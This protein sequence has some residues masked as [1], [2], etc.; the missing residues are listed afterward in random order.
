VYSTFYR[1]YDPAT[2]RFTGVDPLADTTP[3]W[4]PYQF[5][6]GNPIAVNDP[7]GALSFYD[8]SDLLQAI[9]QGK[10]PEGI[11]TNSS[12][13]GGGAANFDLAADIS[14][15]NGRV[16]YYSLSNVGISQPFPNSKGMNIGDVGINAIF[17]PI[18]GIANEKIQ[19][20]EFERENIAQVGEWADHVETGIDMI[21]Y[22]VVR[23]HQEGRFAEGLEFAEIIGKNSGRLAIGVQVGLIG[24]DAVQ[25]KN[26]KIGA[27]TFVFNTTQA[28]A[29]TGSSVVVASAMG[30]AIGGVVGA[31]VGLTVA[32][33]FE[34]VNQLYEYTQAGI[35]S[36][37]YETSRMNWAAY[38]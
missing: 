19:S 31:A 14:T 25:L 16:G 3:D 24:Y 21:N 34:T 30:G 28:V 17:H 1:T 35:D 29:S 9:A 18:K 12:G 13:G 4:N 27:G 8:W 38:H 37:A 33:V 7:T 36:I 22:G 23:M 11:Y 6:L 10:V 32:G 5:A 2:G 20:M 15:R 26:G